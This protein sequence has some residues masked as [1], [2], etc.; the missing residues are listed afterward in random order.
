MAAL[1]IDPLQDRYWCFSFRQMQTPVKQL[2]YNM[3]KGHWTK[4]R[5]AMPLA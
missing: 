3:E 2:F 5:C 1:D 4:I